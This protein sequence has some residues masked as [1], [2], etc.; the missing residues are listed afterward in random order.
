MSH[1]ITLN[2]QL[3][4]EKK[5]PGSLRK[6]GMVRGWWSGMGGRIAGEIRLLRLK[7]Y[8]KSIFVPFL[9]LCCKDNVVFHGA[10]DAAQW[11]GAKT[12]YFQSAF[13]YCDLNWLRRVSGYWIKC[14]CVFVYVSCTL[15]HMSHV[16][17][18]LRCTSQIQRID[19]RGNWSGHLLLGH[20]YVL[21]VME[22]RLSLS[23]SLSH[24]KKNCL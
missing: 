20:T 24:Q 23:L 19:P 7:M 2:E 15:W 22:Q 14:V 13:G 8:C 4:R 9:F 10:T 12:V 16:T 3:R 1:F 5:S 6:L 21:C 17:A 18:H 11:P